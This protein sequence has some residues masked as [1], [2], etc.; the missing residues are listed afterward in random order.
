[1]NLHYSERGVAL[2]QVLLLTAILSVLVLYFTQTSRQQVAVAQYFNDNTDAFIELTNLKNRL[3][4]SLL[5][6]SRASDSAKP[7][8]IIIKNFYGE[9]FFIDDHI[10]VTVQ[11]QAGLL[12]IH[13]LNKNQL[14]NML[15]SLGIQLQ[16]SIQISEMLGNWLDFDN[17]TSN[18]SSETE[19]FGYKAR[20]GYVHDLSDL[21]H[22][23]GL[24]PEEYDMIRR[25]YTIH[26]PGFFNLALAPNSLIKGLFPESQFLQ[27][28]SMR[29]SAAFDSKVF[30]RV[31]GVVE[32][33]EMFFAPSNLIEFELKYIGGDVNLHQKW[34]VSLE[35]YS[36]FRPPINYLENRG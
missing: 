27:V 12:P 23:E 22:I 7:N 24:L 36:D 20:D 34:V 10:Q 21:L 2:I 30:S 17:E 35:P 9:P 16:R 3:L 28:K 33:E 1:M 6:D 19:L 32:S 8:N 18:Y 4:F 29:D 5:T 26:Y 14:V 15:S 11:D 25:A 31:T 13:F